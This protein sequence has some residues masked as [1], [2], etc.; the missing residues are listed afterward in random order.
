MDLKRRSA[1]VSAHSLRG[2]KFGR[3]SCTSWP[4]PMRSRWALR[5]APGGLPRTHLDIY[6][7]NTKLYSMMYIIYHIFA[8][9]NHNI[10]LLTLS[11]RRGSKMTLLIFS[12]IVSWIKLSR[13]IRLKFLQAHSQ[14]VHNWLKFIQIGWLLFVR[15]IDDPEVRKICWFYAKIRIPARPK[16]VTN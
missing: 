11:R 2:Y 8:T 3:R 13:S 12:V 1:S 10:N 9:V 6:N 14:K 16:R 5:A 15:I 4:A 7:N